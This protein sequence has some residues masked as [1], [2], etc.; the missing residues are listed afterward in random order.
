MSYTDKEVYSKV[1]SLVADGG[2]SAMESIAKTTEDAHRMVDGGWSVIYGYVSS[3]NANDL[4]S[5]YDFLFKD[6]E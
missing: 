4:R 6:E 1:A 3:L 2:W 5:R